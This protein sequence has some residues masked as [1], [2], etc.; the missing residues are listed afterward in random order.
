MCKRRDALRSLGV[1]DVLFG[2]YLLAALAVC[3][4]AV[5]D[6]SAWGEVVRSFVGD[7]HRLLQKMARGLPLPFPM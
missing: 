6:P 7:I 3:T 4:I 5:V 2:L 1:R